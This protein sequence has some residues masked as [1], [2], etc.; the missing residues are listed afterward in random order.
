MK[1]RLEVELNSAEGEAWREK[2]SKDTN[3]SEQ[4]LTYIKTKH[5]YSD[6]NAYEWYRTHAD[7][8]YQDACFV[9]AIQFY[10]YCI[11]LQPTENSTYLQRAA[12]YL[13]VFEVN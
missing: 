3:D 5:G 12:C 1:F 4:F 7:Q 6:E 2:L 13:N 10:T 8:F 11:E 9:L